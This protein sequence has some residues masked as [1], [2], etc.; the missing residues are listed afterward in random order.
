QGCEESIRVAEYGSKWRRFLRATRPNPNPW[1]DAPYSRSST[2]SVLEHRRLHNSA[3]APYA[4][5]LTGKATFP[6]RNTWA[7]SSPARRRRANQPAASAQTTWSRSA[8]GHSA[9]HGQAQRFVL[10]A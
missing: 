1:D 3:H 5:R 10:A 4:T 8:A 7:W 2:C 6:K 9:R